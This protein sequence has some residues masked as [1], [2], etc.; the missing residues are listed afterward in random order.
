MMCWNFLASP[1]V[2]KKTIMLEEKEQKSC[3]FQKLK[4]QECE[5]KKREKKDEQELTPLDRLRLS[6]Q[7]NNVNISQVFDY[8]NPDQNDTLTFQEL[9]RG[10]EM[11]RIQFEDDDAKAL[12][13]ALDHDRDGRIIWKHF[14]DIMGGE[15]TSKEDKEKD[16]IDLISP[17]PQNNISSQDQ[18]LQHITGAAGIVIWHPPTAIMAYTI[19]N[20]VILE[21]LAPQ[22]RHVS[23]AKASNQLVLASHNSLVVA[24]AMTEDGDI[25]ASASQSGMWINGFLF[26]FFFSSIHPSTT[27][28]PPYILSHSSFFLPS[29]PRYGTRTLPTNR[30]FHN[31]TFDMEKIRR[32]TCSIFVI[33]SNWKASC[34]QHHKY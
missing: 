27:F 24:L 25:L 1:P 16:D 6:L 30:D 13:E 4:Q 28:L 31:D 17:T 26:F 23:S 12:F 34:L 29:S 2:V 14:Q 20:H 33:R 15:T 9:I 21:S 11:T 5:E 7:K 32:V 22:I 10:L 19:R 18:R 8:M 3:T